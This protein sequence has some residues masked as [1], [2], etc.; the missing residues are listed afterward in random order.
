MGMLIVRS[1]EEMGQTGLVSTE[2]SRRRCRTRSKGRKV[3]HCPSVF[4]NP[5][6]PPMLTAV[7]DTYA[8]NKSIDIEEL[9]LHSPYASE[10]G[11]LKFTLNPTWEHVQVTA[12]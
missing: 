6:L 11:K 12:A 1:L 10:A 2:E 9:I 7:E 8:L 4:S 3:R 5:L